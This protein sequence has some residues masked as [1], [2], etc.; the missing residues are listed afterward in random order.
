MFRSLPFMLMVMIVAF[1]FADAYIPIY[2]KQMLYALSLTIKSAIIFV[3]PFIIFSL[4][5]HTTVNLTSRA[6]GVILIILSAVMC[7]NF[8]AAYLSHYVGEWV[9]QYQF[10]MLVPQQGSNL[11]PLWQM[12]LPA[13]INNSHAM[14]AGIILGLFSAHLTLA[15]RLANKLQY[16]ANLFILGFK[17]IIPVFVAGFVVKLQ[18]DGVIGLIIKDY[19]FIF[20]VI[21]A[22]QVIYLMTIYFIL[23]K[24]QLR[25]TFNAIK[26]MLPAA[27][28]GFSTMSSAAVMPITM[29]SVAMNAKYKT[30]AKTIVPATVNVHLLGDCIA[31]PIFAYALLSSF[32]MPLPSF[33]EYFVFTCYFVIAKFSV[34]AVPGGGILVMLPLLEAYLG[35]TPEMLS[36]ITALYILFD[37]VITCA[38]ILGNGA[39]AKLAGDYLIPNLIHEP[40]KSLAIKDNELRATF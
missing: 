16:V 9:H 6:K 20:A 19:S 28:G 10:A 31:I 14:F 26:N 12:N 37:P 24:L 35:F 7:S 22:S 23:N 34:A 39:M 1:M 32:H 2:I 29:E 4:L 21:A 38:N 17:Y 13:V 8:M 5:F 40:E 18:A 30:M 36:I 15:Q 33:L 25:P 3:L 27:I 11:E